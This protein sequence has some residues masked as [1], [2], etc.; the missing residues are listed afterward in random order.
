S[1][2]PM[3]ILLR[4]RSRASPTPTSPC[5]PTLPSGG[6]RKSGDDALLRP[7]GRPRRR[8][9]E[10]PGTEGRTSLWA[11]AAGGHRWPDRQGVVQPV[12]QPQADEVG[13]RRD[14]AADLGQ[15]QGG[16]RPPGLP[17]WQGPPGGR[18]GLRRLRRATVQDDA[19]VGPSRSC[20]K[21]A[22]P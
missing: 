10:V 3:L 13:R 22:P 20:D 8:A 12:S 16:G 6:R 18:P 21:S 19:A 11:E 17:L 15:L 4:P 9:Q 14:R 2:C 1:P 7:V 5:F